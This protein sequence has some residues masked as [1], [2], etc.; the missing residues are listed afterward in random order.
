MTEASKALNRE[1]KELGSQINLQGEKEKSPTAADAGSTGASTVTEDQ[2]SGAAGPVPVSSPETPPSFPAF[3]FPM[4]PQMM[5]GGAARYPNAMNPNSMGFPFNPMMPMPP[6]FFPNM[7]YNPLMMQPRPMN[8]YPTAPLPGFPP[9][10]PMPGWWM[11]P[12]QVP[13]FGAATAT[14]VVNQMSSSPPSSLVGQSG[15]M[16][17]TSGAPP[18]TS[19]AVPGTSGAAPG[20]SGATPGTSRAAPG[21]SGAAPGTSGVVP[22]TSGAMP[23]TSGVAPDTSGAAPGTS[24]AAP[25][26]SDAAPGP[27]T[28]SSAVPNAVFPP[29]PSQQAKSPPLTIP[30]VPSTVQNSPAQPSASESNFT[31][32]S[33]SATAQSS[34]SSVEDQDLNAEQPSVVPDDP[35]PSAS[36]LRQRSVAR[37][38][39][40]SP[41]VQRTNLPAELPRQQRSLSSSIGRVLLNI[42]VGV[43]ILCIIALL[44]R[45][46]YLLG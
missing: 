2:A 42:L 46:L 22:G 29:G 19:G 4:N 20:T 38:R 17:G 31:A 39:Q 45:R 14:G 10:F 23:G 5:F 21:T 33:A 32:S 28:T 11:N 8:P 30:S 35:V 25:S 26:T 3:P 7:M 12:G 37:G 6:F 27:S 9:G 16:P 18:S 41:V 36:E 15:A 44:S 34:T 40:A 1:A 43:L 13:Q 24:G